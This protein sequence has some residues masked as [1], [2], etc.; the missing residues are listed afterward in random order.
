MKATLSLIAVLLSV[1]FS[2]GT[3][4]QYVSNTEYD[5]ELFRARINQVDEFIGRF[6]AAIA[7]SAKNKEERLLALFDS[8]A[9]GSPQSG[10]YTT[11][12]T[13]VDSVLKNVSVLNYSD[14]TWI[15]VASCH[16]TFLKKPVDFTMFLNVEHQKDDM[17]KWVIA[18]VS[19]EI[20]ELKSKD[21]ENDIKI[22]PHDH[23]TNF[24]I[25]RDIT[26]LNTE[27]IL[28]FSQKQYSIDPTS[29]FYA[30]VKNKMLE[31]EHVTQLQ[32]IFFGVRGWQFSIRYFNRPT[33]NAGWLIDTFAPM[34]D[35]DKDLFLNNFY[36]T[37]C[38]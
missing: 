24:M 23:E 20:F 32:F 18:N 8:E 36:R 28:R 9:L 33:K 4:A 26:T 22:L 3:Y 31:V 35:A 30:Y 2:T 25:L 29:V 13:L 17:Y 38:R 6:N 15:A 10:Q 27:N 1:F 7:D 16:G 12:K 37:K 5:K 19:G 21:M 14:T 34:S 11:A